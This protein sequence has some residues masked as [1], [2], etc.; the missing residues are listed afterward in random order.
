M[1]ISSGD[2]NVLYSWWFLCLS[3]NPEKSVS[4]HCDQN[5]TWEE[6]GE[7]NFIFNAYEQT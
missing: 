4:A 1:S 2:F 6:K 7:T 3:S 5:E